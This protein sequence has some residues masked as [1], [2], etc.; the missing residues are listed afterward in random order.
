MLG[1]LFDPDR[2]DAAF[3]DRL[4]DRLLRGYAGEV[5]RGE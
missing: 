4:V 2:I 5:T 1:A 3:A